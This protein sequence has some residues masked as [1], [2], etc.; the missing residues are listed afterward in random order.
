MSSPVR[1]EGIRAP[2]VDSMLVMTSGP[3]SV[4][5][6]PFT[7]IAESSEAYTCAVWNLRLGSIFV[8]LF[9]R[10]ARLLLSR[11]SHVLGT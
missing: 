2:A 1:K 4:I 9:V 5:L 11:G 7:V 6:V 3:V 10:H 8:C